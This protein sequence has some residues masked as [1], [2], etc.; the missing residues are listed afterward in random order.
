MNKGIAMKDRK[1]QIIIQFIVATAMMGICEGADFVGV[2][3]IPLDTTSIDGNLVTFTP[4]QT[5]EIEVAIIYEEGNDTVFLRNDI[6]RVLEIVMT[7]DGQK[8][9]EKA[10][11][12]ALKGK[13]QT[14]GGESQQE[15][16]NDQTNYFLHPGQGL[17][18]LIDISGEDDTYFT[19]GLFEFVISLRK[20]SLSVGSGGAWVGNGGKA[21]LRFELRDAG[22]EI[23]RKNQLVILA[24]RATRKG[25]YEEAL[26]YFRAYH[27][28]WPTDQ[29]G[30]S[31]IGLTLFKMGDYET[32]IPYLESAYQRVVDTGVRSTVPYSLAYSYVA[33]GKEHEALKV[34]GDYGSPSNAVK[35]VERIKK[36][37]QQD[38]T[39]E[40]QR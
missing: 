27:D 6:L 11:R 16:F 31:G 15:V 13:I 17:R 12:I 22:S 23:D 35:T 25:Q 19:P 4:I 39:T 8:I 37:I 20:G 3:G 7:K 21:G 40:R 33:V 28:S 36:L 2:Y 10:V 24:S 38:T 32:S 14:T 29:V 9:D 26:E 34:L 30:G 1:F 5:F 18:F